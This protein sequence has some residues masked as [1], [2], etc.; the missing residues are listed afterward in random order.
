LH[1][2]YQAKGRSQPTPRE[3]E[4]LGVVYY[5][6]FWYLIAW[7]RLRADFRHFRLDR[8]QHLTLRETTFEPRIGFSL[9]A[10]LD[11]S[12]RKEEKVPARVRF[13]RA[14]AE[15]ARSECFA[16]LV[17]ER[18][19]GGQVEMD[20]LTFSLEWLGRWVLSFGNEAEAV[21]PARLRELVK[22]EA[23][24]VARFYA[25]IPASKHRRRV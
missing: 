17:E 12:V 3:V 13:T 5:G 10:H 2:V 20:F 21:A 18:L 23:E 15:R 1:L 7:C 25:K 19:V 24:A 8:I 16:G 4:P 11:E 14:A 6:S 22:A 9:R